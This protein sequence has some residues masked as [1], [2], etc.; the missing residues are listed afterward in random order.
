MC[1]SGVLVGFDY[2]GK[3]LS[4]SLEHFLIDATFI[5]I[6]VWAFLISGVL[7]RVLFK[8]GHSFFDHYYL[9]TITL[10]VD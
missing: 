8:T 3:L 2:Q 1:E 7:F 10:I 9:S 4:I 6:L 5:F